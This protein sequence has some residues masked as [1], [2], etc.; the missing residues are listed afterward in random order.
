MPL[1]KVQLAFVPLGCQRVALIKLPNW[2]AWPNT[3][4]VNAVVSLFG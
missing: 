2:L 3:F 1:P 4:G